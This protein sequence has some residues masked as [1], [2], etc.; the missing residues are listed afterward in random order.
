M[1]QAK[2]YLAYFLKEKYSCIRAVS[3]KPVIIW[4]NPKYAWKCRFIQQY[5]VLKSILYNLPT[6]MSVEM[7]GWIFVCHFYPEKKNNPEMPVMWLKGKYSSSHGF[8]LHNTITLENIQIMRY[9][10][11]QLWS[12][13]YDL[14][15]SEKIACL[16]LFYWILLNV[17]KRKMVYLGRRR[18]KILFFFLSIIHGITP[19]VFMKFEVHNPGFCS[20][21]RYFLLGSHF[22]HLSVFYLKL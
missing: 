18:Q 13:I 5:T 2:L 4:L 20:V 1:I 21:N 22:S 15:I 3:C 8:S 19:K 7:A 17:Y 11:Y 6:L 14:D 16:M 10:N 12:G 9:V